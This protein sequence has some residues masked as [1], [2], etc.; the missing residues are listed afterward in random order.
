MA[1]RE[2]AFTELPVGKAEVLRE[3]TDVAVIGIGPVINRAL[4]AAENI[5]VYDFKYLKPLDTLMLDSIAAKYRA[6]VT[7]EEGSLKGGLY[8]A[9]TEY[10][11][12]TGYTNPVK[13]LGVPDEFIGHGRQADERAACG[14]DAAGIA[15]AIGSV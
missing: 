1:W 4:E 15:R 10:F 2:A 8:G 3:G 14:L 6:V 13:G 12:Q 9:V 5:G 11:A 7:V